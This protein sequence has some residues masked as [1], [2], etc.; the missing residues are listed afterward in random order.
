V[1]PVQIP[2]RLGPL[3]RHRVTAGVSSNKAR[4]RLSRNVNRQ[5]N[6]AL[7]RIALT[8]ARWHPPAKVLID[9]RKNAGNS[10]REAIRILKRRLS[11]AVFQALLHDQTD[12]LTPA[13]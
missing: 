2:R 5:L 9:R 11:D 12:A 6:G 7:H 1:P 8:Q 4:H 13:A 3:Q 10:G